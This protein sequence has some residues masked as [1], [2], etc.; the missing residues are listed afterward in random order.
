ML[1]IILFAVIM[2]IA[3]SVNAGHYLNILIYSNLNITSVS[4]KVQSGEYQLSGDN[5]PLGA[6]E[7]NTVFEIN[8]VE[9]K[10]KLTKKGKE[11]GTYDSLLING[12]GFI[13][14]MLIKPDKMGER[15]YDNNF[16]I[17]VSNGFLR[18]IN[19]VELENYVAGVVYAECGSFADQNFFVVQSILSRTYALHNINK[20]WKEGYNL[21]DQV[22]CQV[23]KGKTSNTSVLTAV[24]LSNNK[25]IID[26]DSNLISAAFCA[27]CGGQTVNSEDAWT[28]PQT[29]LKTI[30]DTFCIYQKNALWQERVPSEKWLKY[31]SDKYQYPVTDSIAK[32]YALNFKQ[33]Y[34]KVYFDKENKIPLKNIRSDMLFK[35]TC[36]SIT[37]LGD[38]L[39]FQGRGYGHGVGLCQEGALKMSR[40]HYSYLDII[41]FY[42]TDVDIISLEELEKKKKIIIR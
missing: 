6:F 36:F 41:K 15:I 8:V 11:V 12:K 29:Y 2:N 14:T 28:K 4:F 17:S 37:P 23:Y 18:I 9:N 32:Y 42:Y 22:H 38:T 1:K 24:Y 25:V 5:S 27:N 30:V 31:L 21:C 19:H 7:K 40:L 13:N 10:I 20:H 3:I 26:K 34:R 33:P 35:S 16:R 39:L